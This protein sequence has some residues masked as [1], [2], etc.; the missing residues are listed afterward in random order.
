A[1]KIATEIKSNLDSLNEELL[2]S[3]KYDDFNFWETL[4]VITDKSK[5]SWYDI[6]NLIKDFILCGYPS[7]DYQTS[8]FKHTKDFMDELNNDN[9][10]MA[11]N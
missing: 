8:I 6:E 10:L 7:G 5:G 11:N 3:F 4:A 9:Y 1:T 2:S